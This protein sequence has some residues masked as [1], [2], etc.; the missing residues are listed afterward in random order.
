[1][2]SPSEAPSGTSGGSIELER[3]SEVIPPKAIVNGAQLEKE[4]GSDEAK[5]D[6]Q[7]VDL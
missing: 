4:L 1:M 5:D 2:N 7:G 3:T 6:T